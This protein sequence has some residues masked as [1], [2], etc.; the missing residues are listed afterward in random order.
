MRSALALLLCTVAAFAAHGSSGL[1]RMVPE[2]GDAR[3]GCH[4]TATNTAAVRVS[5]TLPPGC[6]QAI[7]V[8]MWIRLRIYDR[9][10]H[11]RV[12]TGSFWCP[13]AID[14]SRPDLL[15]GA[16][17]FGTGGVD[18]TAAGGS[19]AVP[20]FPFAGYAAH[21]TVANSWP[22]GVYTVAGSSEQIVTVS[23]GGEDLALGPGAFNRNVIPGPAGGVVISGAGRAEVGISQ[24]PCHRFYSEMDVSATSGGLVDETT[25]VTNELLLCTWRIACVPGGFSYRHTKGRMAAFD[26]WDNTVQ[27]PAPG[28]QGLSSGGHY[29]VQLYYWGGVLPGDFE[30]FSPRVFTRWLSDGELER[31][32]L[33]DVQEIL[34]RRIPQWRKP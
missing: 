32:H 27:I 3:M 7:T 12:I 5:I 20:Q 1:W 19:I 29:E 17:G 15:A 14:Y 21:P 34:R 8:A 18:L 26:E 31:I 13:D 28:V 10:P 2:L 4:I 6:H 23:V 33:N 30:V 11:L 9:P 24:T 25:S 22:R 16:G